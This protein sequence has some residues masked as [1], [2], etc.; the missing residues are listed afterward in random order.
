LR[1]HLLL[2]ELTLLGLVLYAGTAV[3]KGW[4]QAQAREQKLLRQMVP[5]APAP[6]IPA[7]ARVTPTTP[8]AYLDVA[9]KFVFSRDRNPTVILD[10]PPPPPAPKPMPNLP[11]TYGVMDLG[12]GPTII[13]ADK[14]GGQSRGYRVGERIGEFKLTGLNSHE[15][16][17]DWEG[18]AVKRRI[19][20]LVDKKALEAAPKEQAASPA[21]PA[22]PVKQ[23]N[24]IGPANAGPGVDLGETS[25]ACVPG[26]TSPAGTV[27]D[28]FRKVTR[29]TPFGESC[30]W[31]A[32]N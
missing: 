24:T 14:P 1:K 29:K 23:L 15:V 13:L 32:I 27:Q 22:E 10:P 2:L 17:F 8:A 31:E 20:E 30:R 9:E 7:L 28:G 5:V 18:K 25:R 26:D 21:K 12:G 4:E 19:E 6:V 11:V 3:R 16:T